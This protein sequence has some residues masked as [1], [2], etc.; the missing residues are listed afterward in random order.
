LCRN[1]GKKCKFDSLLPF[2][3]T[4]TCVQKYGYT[5]LIA[6]NGSNETDYEN[7]KIPLYCEC[8]LNQRRL[9]KWRDCDCLIRINRNKKKQIHFKQEKSKRLRYIIYT[10][11]KQKKY[12][13]IY[14]II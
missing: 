3:Y 9:D 13:L 11:K 7:I 1:D 8:M 6:I 12:I 2:G 5:K 4:S 10:T 14:K